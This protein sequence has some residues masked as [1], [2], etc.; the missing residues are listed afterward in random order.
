MDKDKKKVWKKLTHVPKVK[1][2][3]RIIDFTVMPG[4]NGT[5]FTV[6]LNKK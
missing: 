1:P 6:V 5:D 4:P 2:C 3:S